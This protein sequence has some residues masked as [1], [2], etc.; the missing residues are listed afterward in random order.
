MADYYC[1][2]V[3]QPFIPAHFLTEEDKNI[4]AAFNIE[5]EEAENDTL[6]LFAEDWC[7]DAFI[8]DETGKTI[9]L[10]EDDLIDRLQVII[11][12]SN[13]TL[14]WISIEKAYTCSKMCPDGYGGSAIFITADDVRYE[15]TG[16]WL[17]QQIGMVENNQTTPIPTVA[18]VMEQITAAP[19]TTDTNHR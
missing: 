19:S 11:R 5:F 18:V 13:G 14:T 7:T 1:H 15:S 16:H 8:E 17:T 9:D 2:S 12:R 4:F 10:C 3:F 6:Y